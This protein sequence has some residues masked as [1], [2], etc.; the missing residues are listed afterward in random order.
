MDNP[1]FLDFVEFV[2]QVRHSSPDGRDVVFNLFAVDEYA[3]RF[4]YFLCHSVLWLVIFVMLI[5]HNLAK[6]LKWHF[7]GFNKYQ[8]EYKGKRWQIKTAVVG[9]HWF[10]EPYS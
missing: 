9:D 6:K 2:G 3:N 8:F 4:T 1:F 10:E 5:T 7:K